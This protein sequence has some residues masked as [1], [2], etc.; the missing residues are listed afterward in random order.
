MKRKGKELVPLQPVNS[1][2]NAH[3]CE[4]PKYQN[5]W[6]LNSLCERTGGNEASVIANCMSG[7]TRERLKN[8]RTAKVQIRLRGQ[9]DVS[10]GPNLHRRNPMTYLTLNRYTG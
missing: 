9:Q 4:V 8:P 5:C 2:Y 6:C 3:N 7:V 10:V 1:F